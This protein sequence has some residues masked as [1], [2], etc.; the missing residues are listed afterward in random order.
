MDTNYKKK[1]ITI[2]QGTGSDAL[3]MKVQVTQEEL[4]KMEQIRHYSPEQWEGI[5]L[6]LLQEARKLIKEEANKAQQT[7]NEEVVQA[8]PEPKEDV[9]KKGNP[10]LWWTIGILAAFFI[11]IKIITGTLEKRNREAFQQIFQNNPGLVNEVLGET[12]THEGLTFK[13]PR[14]WS[15]S[16]NDLSDE[17]FMIGGTDENDSEFGVIWTTNKELSLENYIDNVIAGYD[18]SPNFNGFEYSAIYDTKVNG[19]DA[20]V[21]DYSY[22]Y[23]GKPSYA[24]II[25]FEN[26]KYSV[27][28]NLIAHSKSALE[29]DFNVMKNSIRFTDK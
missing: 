12:I 7:A 21:V 3:E 17:M 24:Q 27:F 4:D 22:N 10:G 13:Y 11:I 23:Q 26:N 6:E 5:E 1:T 25:G 15:L 18:N 29:K 9:Q 14:N 8:S 20:I 19:M 28:L 2:I 16:T